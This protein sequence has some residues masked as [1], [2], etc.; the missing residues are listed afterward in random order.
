VD[1]SP[2]PGAAW[3]SGRTVALLFALGAAGLLAAVLVPAQLPFVDMPQHYALLA[4]W[5]HAGEAAWGL[6]PTFELNLATPYVLGYAVAYLLTPLLGEELA[7][8]VVLAAGLV[9]LPAAAWLFLRAF[10]RPT[11]LCL[12]AFPVALSWLVF[13]GWFPYVIGLPLA[14]VAFAVARHVALHG[15]R[16]DIAILGIIALTAL[17]THALIFVLTAAGALLVAL[18]GPA[19]RRAV[20]RTAIAV[21]PAAVLGLA[22]ALLRDGLA[23]PEPRPILFGPISRRLDLAKVLFGSAGDDPRVIA[24]AVGLAAVAIVAI[25]L[26]VLEVRGDPPRE[27]VRRWFTTRGPMLPLFAG[28]ALASLL[29]PETLF[30]IYGVW[31]RTVP[32]AFIVGLGLAPWPGRERARAALAAGLAVVALLATLSALGQGLAYS[33]ESAGIREI[34]AELPAGQRIFTEAPVDSSSAVGTRINRHV[35]GYY[36][37]TKGGV[38]M[39]DF[40]LYPYQVVVFSE[41]GSTRYPMRDFDLYL[42]RASASCPVPPPDRPVGREIARVGAW[43][44]FE[45][46]H[47]S[48]LDGPTAWDLPCYER[49]ADDN[50]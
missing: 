30:D 16:R 10:D 38:M 40:S 13:R 39:D 9:A 46:D 11:E 33:E 22:W 1:A 5:T 26:V 6:P 15:R 34:V 41:P 29:L 23:H 45:V 24:V 44:A 50:E 4:R 32:V 47:A 43:S 2:R 19:R 14:L 3:L 35:A 49:N 31:H 27:I 17:A 28:L 12:A 42:F 7:I 8:R 18:G 36:V 25:V 21:A 37:V 20:V 48:G